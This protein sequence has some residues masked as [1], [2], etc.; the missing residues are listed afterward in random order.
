MGAYF[1]RIWTK[2]GQTSSLGG[3][4]SDYKVETHLRELTKRESSHRT[5]LRKSQKVN[6]KTETLKSLFRVSFQVGSLRCATAP[7]GLSL[8]KCE[9]EVLCDS[10]S[11]RPSGPSAA[12]CRRRRHLRGFPFRRC[13]RG[14][15]GAQRDSKGALES[16]LRVS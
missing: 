3:P 15:K 4:L 9:S 7:Q 10:V 11:V 8:R 5:S 2:L 16:L 6:K 14:S 13:E 12:G 1:R